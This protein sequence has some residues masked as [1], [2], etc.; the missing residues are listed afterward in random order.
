MVGKRWNKN[1]EKYLLQNYPNMKLKEIARNLNRTYKSLLSKTNRLKITISS[2]EKFVNLLRN[3]KKMDFTTEPIN[4]FLAGLI[5]GEGCFTKKS[6]LKGF[7]FSIKMADRD[8]EILEELK[9]IINAG[10]IYLYKKRKNLWEDECVFI[11]Q[12]QIDIHTK[13]IPFMNKFLLGSFKRKQFLRWKEEFYTY[14]KIN[15]AGMVSKAA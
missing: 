4:Y 12:S 6:K 5:A 8:K 1:D 9:K 11:I 13:L 10:Y 14:Y 3:S 7:S 15:F 2:E